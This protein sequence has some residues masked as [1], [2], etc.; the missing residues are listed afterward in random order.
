VTYPPGY[1]IFQKSCEAAGELYELFR[2]LWGWQLKHPLH[3]FVPL[4]PLQFD[5]KD[6]LVGLLKA[7]FDVDCDAAEAAVEFR[8]CRVQLSPN[9]NGTGRAGWTDRN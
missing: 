4:Y 8:G 9:T 7:L 3:I 6:L 1:H 5:L 2:K